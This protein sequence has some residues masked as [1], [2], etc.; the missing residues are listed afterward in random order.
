[1][2]LL[3]DPPK[4]LH[5]PFPS[6]SKTNYLLDIATNPEKIEKKSKKWP[7]RF[8]K[9]S[10]NPSQ[11]HFK[12][13]KKQCLK[14]HWFSKRL[15]LDFSPLWPPKSNPKASLLRV[16]LKNIDFLIIHTKHWLCAEKSRF[17]LQKLR[18]NF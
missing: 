10:Q 7:T 8:P 14:T 2:L 3:P 5:K 4:T 11:I 12:F 18:E 16:V 13:L 6:A 9:P 15:F 17:D 1:M